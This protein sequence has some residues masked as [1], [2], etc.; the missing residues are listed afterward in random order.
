[1]TRRRRPLLA[2]PGPVCLICDR[3]MT[4]LGD[5]HTTHPVCGPYD[6]PVPSSARRPVVEP[7]LG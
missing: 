5:G 4:Y 6:R 2:E 7:Q 3:R 1:M